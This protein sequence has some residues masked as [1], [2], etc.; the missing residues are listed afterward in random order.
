MSASLSNVL[1]QLPASD[2]SWDHESWLH[3]K[4]K[5]S[6]LLPV[7]EEIRVG[8]VVIFLRQACQQNGN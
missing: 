3:R 5:E 7:D 1:E 6:P 8:G 2:I 4:W